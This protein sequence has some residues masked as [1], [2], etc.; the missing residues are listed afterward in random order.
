LGGGGKDSLLRHSPDGDILARII[1]VLHQRVNLG[2]FTIFIKI[3]AHRGEFLNKK[4]ERWVDEGRDNA[5]NVRWDGPDSHSTFSW[6]DAGVE[7]RC[8]MNQTLLTRVHLKV[9]KLQLPLHKNFTS[10]FLN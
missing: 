3:R 8:C 4:S 5:G 7:H 9:A 2:L 1:K 6:T 10:A